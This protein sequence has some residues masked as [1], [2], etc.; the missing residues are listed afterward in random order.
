V[1][2]GHNSRKKGHDTGD[3]TSS[4]RRVEPPLKLLVLAVFLT[5]FVSV[6]TAK[7]GL[8]LVPA[9]WLLLVLG[10]F[11][12]ARRDLRSGL[13]DVPERRLAA[14]SAIALCIVAGIA[15]CIG[16]LLYSD[17]NLQNLAT[18]DD[19][20]RAIGRPVERGIV[21]QLRLAQGVAGFLAILALI[22][23]VSTWRRVASAFVAAGVVVSLYGAYQVL[24]Q[25]MFGTVRQPPAAFPY[26]E[27]LRASGPFP[28]PTAY[29]GFV[30]FA[31]ACGVALI[32]ERPTWRLYGALAVLT[33]GLLISRSTVAIAFFVVP[34]AATV[35]VNR[36][37]F[38]IVAASTV[39]ALALVVMVGGTGDVREVIEKPFGVQ[40]SLVDRKASWEA[41]GRMGL[42]YAPIG[43]GRG[44]Y[45]YNT[46]PF[47]D[48]AVVSRAGRAQSAALEMWAET[49]PVGVALLLVL[50]L[51]AAVT[52]WRG[53]P[54]IKVRVAVMMMIV[55]LAATYAV[56]Y[57][58]T[59]AW[60]WVALALT[61]T[62]PL[63]QSSA[64]RQAPS[65]GQTAS[66]Q[67][68]KAG[69]R[70][71]S[72][73]FFR[74]AISTTLSAASSRFPSRMMVGAWDRTAP[75][76]LSSGPRSSGTATVS[77]RNPARSIR[78]WIVSSVNW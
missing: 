31:I 22:R 3:R 45:A 77:I 47:L 17:Q 10:T 46:A 16:L 64:R 8:R 65:D 60:L 19:L 26:P 39:S 6:G 50:F 1:N 73:L 57:T 51:I 62:G 7:F 27:L 33:V 54:P 9:D 15:L 36:R 30:L 70:P 37:A 72:G 43:V 76:R 61:I 35:I 74:S 21:D 14:V 29:A 48:P 71:N 12:L 24:S 23:S 52:A 28:E 40:N 13:F 66:L 53:S 32:A 68:Q 56:Y 42:A 58:S 38:A 34:V 41:A 5:P 75:A 78:N 67:P 63:V 20:V 49:G 25:S 55:V 4:G 2:S 44:Q 11:V 59:Y 18:G 69:S